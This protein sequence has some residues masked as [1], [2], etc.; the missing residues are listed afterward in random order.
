MH[1][2]KLLKNFRMLLTIMLYYVNI[3]ELI[4]SIIKE[5]EGFI[6]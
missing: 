1:Y 6:W 3:I 5:T 2:K 4:P